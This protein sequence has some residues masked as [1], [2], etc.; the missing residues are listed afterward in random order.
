MFVNFSSIEFEFLGRFSWE[1]IVE[2]RFWGVGASLA[3]G[4]Q[5]KYTLWD[6]FSSFYGDSYLNGL[7]T[8]EG[9]FSASFLMLFWSFS[10]VFLGEDS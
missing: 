1:K 9:L 5:L 3:I 8:T 4:L 2:E 7:W 10:Q 6:W